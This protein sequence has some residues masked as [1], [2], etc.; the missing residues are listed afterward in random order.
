[1]Y[2]RDAIKIYALGAMMLLV[3]GFIIWDHA[4]PEWQG[5]QDDFRALVAKRFGAAS[6]DQ[7]PQGLRQI[8]VKDLDRVDR[9]VTCHQGIEWKGLENAPNPFKSHPQEILKSHPIDQFGCA[10]CH[11]GQGYATEADAA[12]GRVEHWE[13]PLLGK[14][15]SDLYL[16]KDRLVRAFRFR[17]PRGPMRLSKNTAPHTKA[18]WPA[19]RS[20]RRAAI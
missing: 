18:Q 17:C 15:L 1:M 4:A 3:T 5:Y 14:R 20:I 9:C 16:V 13:E 2:T 19:S 7:V 8:W 10:S 11:G 12:H 6:A